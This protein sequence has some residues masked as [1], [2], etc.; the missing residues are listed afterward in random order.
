MPVFCLAFRSN[1]TIIFKPFKMKKLFIGLILFC[2]I[3]CQTENTEQGNATKQL[4]SNEEQRIEAILS[5]MTLEEKIGQTALR[6]S[7]SSS[8]GGLSEE[9][10]NDLKAGRIGA[11]LNVMD[12]AEMKEIQR[13][14]VEESPNGIPVVFIL[15]TQSSQVP[16][17]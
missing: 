11:F 10:I 17:I 13:L 4:D 6:G 14:A 3:A 8:K 9:L 16:S 5:K 12:P 2:G 15:C 7:S 1:T